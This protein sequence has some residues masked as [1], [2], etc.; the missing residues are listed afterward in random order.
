[1]GG[2]LPPRR[3]SLDVSVLLGRASARPLELKHTKGTRS[4]GSIHDDASE[5]DVEAPATRRS[6]RAEGLVDVAC[7]GYRLLVQPDDDCG[8]WGT[9]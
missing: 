1:M 3:A 7:G 9:R 5:H 6:I 2:G 4:S 8:A